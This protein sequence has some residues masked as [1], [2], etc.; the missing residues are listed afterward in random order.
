MKEDPCSGTKSDKA[1]QTCTHALLWDLL[2]ACQAASEHA[3]L[4]LQEAY[5]LSAGDILAFGRTQA[6]VMTICGELR[7]GGQLTAATSAPE[8]IVVTLDRS[9]RRRHTRAPYD[10]SNQGDDVEPRRGA[11]AVEDKEVSS[12]IVA[13]SVGS[14]PI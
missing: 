11:K 3:T 1:V 13:A 6:G 2:H 12:W 5:G 8:K 9:R 10:P 14:W 4:S 7:P